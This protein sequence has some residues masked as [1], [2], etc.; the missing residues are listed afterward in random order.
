MVRVHSE[1]VNVLYTHDIHIF[2]YVYYTLKK[3]LLRKNN[4]KG[5]R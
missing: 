4:K 1:K 2:P 3:Y 5:S